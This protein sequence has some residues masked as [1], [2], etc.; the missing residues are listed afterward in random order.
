M[1]SLFDCQDLKLFQHLWYSSG[2]EP[3]T[4]ASEA[5]AIQIRQ[6]FVLSQTNITRL[7]KSIFFMGYGY[8]FLNYKTLQS[9]TH[10]N[11]TKSSILKYYIICRT[12]I[13]KIISELGLN[14]SKEG[15]WKRKCTVEQPLL[16]FQNVQQNKSGT[17]FSF[18]SEIPY[19]FKLRIPELSLKNSEEGNWKE[20][21]G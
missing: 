6:H 9:E 18:R 4:F 14:N 15:N 8:I 5:S 17:F 2:I 7:F 21:I 12:K 3:E 19:H 10:G 16:T 11:T 1:S 13:P 20:K